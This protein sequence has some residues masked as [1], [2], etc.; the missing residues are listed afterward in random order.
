MSKK[1]IAVKLLKERTMS[2]GITVVVICIAS[3]I[4][5]PI[6]FATFD[7][8]SRILLGVA[9]NNNSSNRNDASFDFRRF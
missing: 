2:L 3:A 6:S 7:N 1:G 8:I 9:T 5:W 4:I